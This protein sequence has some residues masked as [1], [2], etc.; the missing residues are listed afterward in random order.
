M[1]MSIRCYQ[2]NDQWT[3]HSWPNWFE[4]SLARFLDEA[5][6][7]DPADYDYIQVTPLN[8]YKPYYCGNGGSQGFRHKTTSWAFPDYCRQRG[9]CPEVWTTTKRR[10]LA[11]SSDSPIW[12][13]LIIR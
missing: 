11:I 1:A 12:D 3:N 5:P 4:A 10:Q 6:S 7:V 8:Q 9:G 2:I 13:Y